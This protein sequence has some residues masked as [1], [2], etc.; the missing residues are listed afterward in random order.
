MIALLEYTQMFY[1]FY[2]YNNIFTKIKCI[3]KKTL[4]TFI[5]SVPHV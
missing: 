4:Y 2:N 3:Y 1:M 5:L